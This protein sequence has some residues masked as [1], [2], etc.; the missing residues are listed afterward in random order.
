[1][2]LDTAISTVCHILLFLLF[3]PQVVHCCCD[4]RCTLSAEHRRSEP[5]FRARAKSVPLLNTAAVALQIVDLMRACQWLMNRKPTTHR[6]ATRSSIRLIDRLL[7]S[8]L[9]K[10]S[11]RLHLVNTWLF[12]LRFYQRF[13]RSPASRGS[14][15]AAF[16]P[17][18][19]PSD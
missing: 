19:S 10:S 11:S 6:S 13:W 4:Q 18:A 14:Q 5:R 12:A 16:T 17:S 2:V 9:Q 3:T 1:M 7:S 15:S 8:S